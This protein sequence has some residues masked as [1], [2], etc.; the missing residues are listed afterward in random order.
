MAAKPHPGIIHSMIDKITPG[1]IEH[2][3]EIVV[4]GLG[5]FG[6][7]LARAL[8]DMGQEVL[9]IDTDPR[10]VQ[11]HATALTHVVQADST[12][13][14]ALRQIGVDGA[15]TVVVC[16]GNDI[17]ASVLTTSVLSDMGTPNIWAKAI[18]AQHGRI[19]DRVGAHHVV[20]PEANMGTRVAHLITGSLLEYVAL[21]DDFVIV[22]TAVPASYAGQT[23]GAADLRSTHRV[24]VVCIKPQGRTFTYAQRDTV[25]GAEDLIVV[26]GHR[27][28]IEHFAETAKQTAG[29]GDPTDR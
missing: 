24:T 20:F 29:S 22:E 11:E 15:V 18:T 10:R 7:A 26:A 23:L 28:D 9:A 5:R 1:Q 8:V 12:S 13:E 21:D 17:E 27:H 25:L 4:I 19:L 2:R 14:S 3:G 16:I 6:S